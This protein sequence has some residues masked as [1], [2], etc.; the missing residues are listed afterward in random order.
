MRGNRLIQTLVLIAFVMVVVLIAAPMPATVAKVA[1]GNSLYLPLLVG[2][3]GSGPAP[4]S[5]PSSTVTNTPQVAF[6]DTPQ[7]QATITLTPGQVLNG[8]FEQGHGVGWKEYNSRN[9]PT[10][11][12]GSSLN[13][14]VN[15]HSGQWLATLFALEL[16]E[17]SQVGQR[18]VLPSGQSYLN[19]YYAITSNEM[20][21]VPWYDL[22]R[23]YIN[24]VKVVDW[25]VCKSY[26]VTSNWTP[27]FIDLTGSG[28]TPG[29]TLDIV[30]EASTVGGDSGSTRVYLD[31]FS[32]GPTHY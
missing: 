15:A 13:P 26:Y 32:L 11:W 8:G 21:D 2:G 22:V 31:D 25:Q 4:S 16:G 7:P 3:S 24:T 28:Y 5:M 29:Q 27:A 20:C 1:G 12:M 17:V 14:P 30:F 19:F 10:V 18:L 23:I 9:L 6:T